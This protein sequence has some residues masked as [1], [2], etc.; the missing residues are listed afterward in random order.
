MPSAS[1]PR[2]SAVSLGTVPWLS[3]GS[4]TLHRWL[5]YGLGA[6]VALWVITGIVLLFPPAPSTRQLESTS[7][8]LARAE[9]TPSEAARALPDEM[10]RIRSLTLRNVGGRLVYDFASQRGRHILVDATT[11]QRI[12]LTDSLALALAR[13]VMI[14][15]AVS[16]SVR[17]ITQ[18]DE[19]YRFGTL[20]AY[21]IE[22]NDD[23]HTVIHVGADATITSSTS[24]SRLR[25]IFAGLHEFRLPGDIIPVR[26]RRGLLIVTGAL[27]II[28]VLTGYVLSLPVR[29]RT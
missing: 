24:R 11:A 7:I 19:K 3:R 25:A 10:Q 21:R 12:E 6:I 16:N 26:M 9:R 2:A 13:R 8:D 14:D 18:F 4:R 20:P 15:S 29:R 17:Q 27:A 23:A 22:L 1:P 28:L 5:A